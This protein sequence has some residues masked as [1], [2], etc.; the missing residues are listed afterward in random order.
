M[1][2]RL[3]AITLLLL[4]LWIVGCSADKGLPS[5]ISQ[6]QNSV[7]KVGSWYKAD[8]PGLG[9]N[10]TFKALEVRD[11]AWIKAELSTRNLRDYRLSNP[12]WL[13]SNQ[14]LLVQELGQSE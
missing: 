13:N 10:P 7:F 5:D 6:S 11:D 1:E 2:R 3:Q 4:L 8:I 14:F 9:I 12:V